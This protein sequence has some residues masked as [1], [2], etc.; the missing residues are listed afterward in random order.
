MKTW[1]KFFV[2]GLLA[3][4]ATTAALAQQPVVSVSHHHQLDVLNGA[5]VQRPRDLN[6]R[7]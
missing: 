2:S 7:G 4:F 3:A 6:R 1:I 5:F